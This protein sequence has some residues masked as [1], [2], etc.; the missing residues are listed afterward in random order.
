MQD[1]KS[2]R[3]AGTARI[4][5]RTDGSR[6]QEREVYEERA[7]LGRVKE[8]QG[9][10]VQN[11]GPAVVSIWGEHKWNDDRGD[12][13]IEGHTQCG[14][15][16]AGDSETWKTLDEELYV[17]ARTECVMLPR[18]NWLRLL[19]G[20]TG[21]RSGASVERMYGWLLNERG[22]ETEK[23]PTATHTE[24]RRRTPDLIVKLGGVETRWE[25]KAILEENQERIADEQ[26]GGGRRATV[27]NNLRK[28]GQQLKAAAK[29]GMP[30]VVGLANLRTWDPC[31]TGGEAIAEALFGCEIARIDNG[32]TWI[33]RRE[34]DHRERYRTISGI[35]T[36]DFHVAVAPSEER[37]KQLSDVMDGMMMIAVV[38]LYHNPYADVALPTGAGKA[39][40]AEE[41]AWSNAERKEA[42][43]SKW[44]TRSLWDGT[45]ETDGRIL[46]TASGTDQRE[47]RGR[48]AKEIEW[49]G[50]GLKMMREGI[51]HTLREQVL[52]QA[53]QGVV[54]DGEIR[55]NRHGA[56]LVEEGPD[57]ED[58]WARYVVPG[59]R[60]RR[61]PVIAGTDV[62]V[63]EVLK[64]AGKDVP[65][66]KIAERTRGSILPENDPAA[67]VRAA[68]AYAALVLLD[69]DELP[70]AKGKIERVEGRCNGQPVLKDTRQTVRSILER[71]THG[72]SM[73]KI[74]V[75]TERD[76]EAIAEAVA[77]AAEAVRA[78]TARKKAGRATCS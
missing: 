48:R 52:S 55:V 27:A 16:A 29:A 42:L 68:A 8:G 34:D 58:T 25:L 76:S 51:K 72:A 67:P 26:H 60:D 35:A 74:R 11:E 22:V 31:A 46:Q 28:A 38:Q 59:E 53:G 6:W 7:G 30:T 63:V 32:K 40:L 75:E 4:R 64:Q 41:H 9:L 49:A 39:L 19:R 61:T 18:D 66:E 47:N 33:D 54:G 43:L 56:M 73:A 24:R 44:T 69:D 78:K 12:I 21:A 65:Y 14:H 36:L 50:L 37:G 77:Y 1:W 20:E 5:Y 2:K 15:L 57:I 3:P 70:E 23:I 71:M 13:S 62:T 10:E 17:Q 45:H